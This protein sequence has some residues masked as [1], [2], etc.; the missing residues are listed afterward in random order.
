MR[1]VPDQCT[2]ID[3]H[4]MRQGQRA[5]AISVQG[6]GSGAESKLKLIRRA[7][8]RNPT[9]RARSLHLS[10]IM[11][12][13]CCSSPRSPPSSL[14]MFAYSLFKYLNRAMRAIFFMTFYGISLSYTNS[15]RF[16][17]RCQGWI[18]VFSARSY[19]NSVCIF[20]FT[21]YQADSGT[22]STLY[23]VYSK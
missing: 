6:T 2:S 9:P 16:C 8:G 12:A 21:T 10:F 7:G 5:I 19:E 3:I 1:V 15:L 18:F 4:V 23:H 11:R 20:H 14:F 17:E 22:I 13:I